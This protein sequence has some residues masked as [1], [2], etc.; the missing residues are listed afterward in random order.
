[1]WRIELM[2]VVTKSILEVI[3]NVGF[4][5]DLAFTDGTKRRYGYRQQERRAVS[6]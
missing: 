2:D 1:M 6:A 3:D 4:N 5:V